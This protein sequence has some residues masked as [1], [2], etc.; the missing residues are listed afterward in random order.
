MQVELRRLAG[1]RA[2]R[3]HADTQYIAIVG[4]QLRRG[5]IEPRPVRIEVPAAE[6]G[7]GVA[8]HA[9]GLGVTGHAAL[10]A[11]ARGLTVARD[12]GALRGDLRNPHPREVV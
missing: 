8:A 5:Q 6:R 12:E 2:D 11:L 3:F 4:Q 7:C 9:V 10:E 1:I